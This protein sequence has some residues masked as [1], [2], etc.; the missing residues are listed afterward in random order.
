MRESTMTARSWVVAGALLVIGALWTSQTA[1]PR[2]GTPPIAP[3]LTA[4]AYA[5][6]AVGFTRAASVTGRRPLGT[7]ALLALSA[8]VLVQGYI[9]PTPAN[10]A[11]TVAGGA[12]IALY[13]LALLVLMLG[14]AIVAAVEI[15]RVDVVPRPWRWVPLGGAVAFAVM[16]AV[17]WV[18]PAPLT[19]AWMTVVGVVSGVV[20]LGVP[21]LLGFVA[22]FLGVERAADRA[23]A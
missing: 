23:R 5:L 21:L 18:M 4:A 9:D 1:I 19:E 16:Q 6:F 15:A 3:A 22:I 10:E 2:G 17:V 11:L 8:L 13:S 20:W 7:V 12:E 14:A